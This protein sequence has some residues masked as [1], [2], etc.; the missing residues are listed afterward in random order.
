MDGLS[1]LTEGLL[2]AIKMCF[3]NRLHLPALILLYSSIDIMSWLNCDKSSKDV[4]RKD[5]IDWVNDYLLPD[6]K[7]G[8]SAID[9]YAAR[10]GLVHTAMAESNLSR[11]GDAKGIIYSW[12]TGSKTKLQKCSDILGY[13][14]VAIHFDTLFDAFCSG[15]EEFKRSLFNDLEKTNLVNERTKKLLIADTSPAIVDMLLKNHE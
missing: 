10:C 3:K 8:C 12:G 9:L 7:I 14:L 5:F 1:K 13:S 6:Q 15:V 11:K 2:S 4:T